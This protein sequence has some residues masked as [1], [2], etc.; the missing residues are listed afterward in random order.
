MYKTLTG[1]LPQMGVDYRCLSCV[2]RDFTRCSLEEGRSDVEER[3][4][5]FKLVGALAEVSSSVGSA[6]GQHNLADERSE[7]E[8]KDAYLF[9][10]VMQ[11][12]CSSLSRFE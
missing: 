6:V 5:S 7:L 4:I 1:S 9:F 12:R 11:S 3:E 10:K 8:A 2:G